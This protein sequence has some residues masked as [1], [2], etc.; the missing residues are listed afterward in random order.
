MLRRWL[1]ALVVFLGVGLAVLLSEQPTGSLAGRVELP[2]GVALESVRVIAA[3]PATRSSSLTA[4]GEYR[5]D[6]LPVGEYQV[7]VQGSG[8]ETVG[9]QGSVLVREGAT[10]R[11]PTLRP[12]LVPPRSL[13]LQHQ[14]GVYDRRT[15]AAAVAGHQPGL[16]AAQP[17]SLF[18]DR[19]A[20]IPSLARFGGCWLWLPE[21]GSVSHP[22]AGA[23]AQLAAAGATT[24]GRGVDSPNLGAGDPAAGGLLGGG[25][26][27][28]AAECGCTLAPFRPLVF[29][30]RSRPHPE[31]GCQPVGGAGGAPAGAASPGRDPDPSFRGVGGSPDG[32]HRCRG[33][34]PLWPAGERGFFPGGLW[35]QCR[36]H[37]AGF[38]PQLCL[39]LEPAP[40]DLRLHRSSPLPSWPNRLFP[41]P[42]ARANP[43]H[44]AP[45]RTSSATDPYG[46]QR[47]CVE[48]T[49]PGH[50][51]FWQCPWGVSTARRSVPGQLRPGVAG[52]R[53][54]G[55]QPRIHLF[56][57]GSLPQAGV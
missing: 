46:P 22:A 10:V 20:G 40:P 34:G 42:G 11:I 41:R 30:E 23:C 8:L 26:G 32:H 15:G 13:S 16:G 43:P 3:G 38:V 12:Q 4:D 7:T 5:L 9:S 49:N 27:P 37:P 29:G 54:A 24:S 19:A 6:R 57:G 48:R 47:G 1:V 55:I 2:A 14:P 31:A 18:P 44:A 21:S 45:G 53:A 35:P 25:G 36:Q 52:V 50:Q 33:A 56:S 28:G 17:L 39:W 51:C